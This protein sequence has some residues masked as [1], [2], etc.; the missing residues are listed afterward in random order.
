MGRVWGGL[1]AGVEFT[2]F[3]LMLKTQDALQMTDVPIYGQLF[4]IRSF[5]C[6][7]PKNSEIVAQDPSLHTSSF[8]S[9]S[10]SHSLSL[11]L[12]FFLAIIVVAY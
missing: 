7:W 6:L 3:S 9:L 4:F 10:L 11:F 12:S 8:F 2:K 5:I 1:L